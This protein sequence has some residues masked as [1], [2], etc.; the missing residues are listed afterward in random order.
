MAGTGCRKVW[1]DT[2]EQFPC[3]SLGRDQAK[4]QC[5]SSARAGL[6]ARLLSV[7]DMR[8]LKL[9]LF[10]GNNAPGLI[11]LSPVVTI[12]CDLLLGLKPAG[13]ARESALSARVAI[14]WGC[15]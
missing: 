10:L 5:Q 4:P 8:F 3:Q 7:Y 15:S 12:Y 9:L 6:K 2:K 1:Q 14:T 13:I 11:Y